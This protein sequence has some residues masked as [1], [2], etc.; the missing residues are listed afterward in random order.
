MLNTREPGSRCARRLR[1]PPPRLAPGGQGPRALLTSNPRTFGPRP[2]IRRRG[3]AAMARQVVPSALARSNPSNLGPLPSTPHLAPRHLRTF[4]PSHHHCHYT[5]PM[6]CHASLTGWSRRGASPGGSSV[7]EVTRA[8]RA[9]S[10]ASCRAATQGGCGRHAGQCRQACRV[11]PL[12]A[13]ALP[14][15]GAHR[16]ARPL[17][18]RERSMMW[19]ARAAGA[20]WAMSGIGASR[21]SGFDRH[22]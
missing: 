2:R 16:P 9:L 6:F 20:A 8:L 18:C 1:A 22:P 4:A 11:R 21:V 12:C 10:S 13:A 7:P 5:C 15:Y 3:F 14:G 17:E 19:M